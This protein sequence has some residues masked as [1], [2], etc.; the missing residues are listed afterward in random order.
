M[1]EIESGHIY[2][3]KMFKD[4]KHAAR[5]QATRLGLWSRIKHAFEG[6]TLGERNDIVMLARRGP[7]ITELVIITYRETFGSDPKVRVAPVLYQVFEPNSLKGTTL[8]HDACV[9]VS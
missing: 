2:R 1:F 5:D 8:W 3:N 7:Y 4:L 9:E 6:L